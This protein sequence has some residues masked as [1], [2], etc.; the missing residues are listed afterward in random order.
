M[1][2]DCRNFKNG[3]VLT[4]DDINKIEQALAN[5]CS[6]VPPTCDSKDCSMVLSYSENGFEWIPLK[7]EGAEKELPAVTA[8]DNG[9]FLRV[10][11]S[12]WAAGNLPEGIATETYVRQYVESANVPPASI[13]LSQYES[14]G[15]IVETFAD[16]TAKTTTVE[17]DDNGK[18]VKITDSAGNVTNLTW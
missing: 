16:G 4:A 11:D 18:P 5:V 14:A 9:K 13:D 17:F 3:Q 1:D 12:A 10:V 15:K 7:G 6:A 8:E 2:Y